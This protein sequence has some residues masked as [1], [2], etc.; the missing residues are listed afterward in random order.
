M[1]DII[2][3]LLER[4]EDIRNEVSDLYNRM[5]EDSAEFDEDSDEYAAIMDAKDGL[6][7]IYDDLDLEVISALKEAS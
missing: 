2:A 4:A 7:C 6:S 5:I 3:G 1:N